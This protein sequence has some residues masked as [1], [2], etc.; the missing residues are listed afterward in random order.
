MK[1]GFQAAPVRD[2]A[3]PRPGVTLKMRAPRRSMKPQTV[4]Q[5]WIKPA[6]ALL[7]PRALIPAKAATKAPPLTVQKTH[8]RL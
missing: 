6:N 2:K 1:M 3:R 5:R 8:L 4:V 7:L